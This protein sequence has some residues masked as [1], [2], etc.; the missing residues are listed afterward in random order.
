MH[1]QDARMK[2]ILGRRLDDTVASVYT[3]STSI[4]SSAVILYHSSADK[5]FPEGFLS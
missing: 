3:S 2:G 5:F 1:I 4:S